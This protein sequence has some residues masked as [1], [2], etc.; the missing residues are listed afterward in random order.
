MSGRQIIG[1]RLIKVGLDQWEE[2]SLPDTW[3]LKGVHF[4]GEKAYVLIMGP[5]P[6]E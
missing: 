4:E 5:V 3:A 2:F 6:H 1:A